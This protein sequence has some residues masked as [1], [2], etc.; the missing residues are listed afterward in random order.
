MVCFI[1]ELH[2]NYNR[3]NNCPC[4]TNSIAD[5]VTLLTGRK[6]HTGAQ[7]RV[8]TKGYRTGSFAI[9]L[10]YN[11]GAMPSPFFSQGNAPERER[12]L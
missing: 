5:A 6:L 10:I 3:E 2:F 7:K 1:A 4:R 9:E 11:N 12:S 8:E